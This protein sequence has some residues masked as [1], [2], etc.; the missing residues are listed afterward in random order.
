MIRI[1]DLEYVLVHM[2]VG[3]A[4]G[5]VEKIEFHCV[6]RPLFRDLKV[7]EEGES[8]GDRKSARFS[9]THELRVA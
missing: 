5:N 7:E 3:I 9:R 6:A 4:T 2:S 1:D 8:L